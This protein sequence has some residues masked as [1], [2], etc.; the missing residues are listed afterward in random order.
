[1]LRGISNISIP[2]FNEIAANNGKMSFP[3]NSSSLVYSHLRHVSGV[4]A[5]DGSQG[6]TI[7]K[8]HLLDA[9]IGQLNKIKS[10]GLPSSLTESSSARDIEALIENYRSQIMQARAANEAMPYTPSPGNQSGILFNLT[11]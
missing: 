11:T 5:P 4:Q 2:H 1:M 3:V 7:S 6:I 10:E 8:L 9:L